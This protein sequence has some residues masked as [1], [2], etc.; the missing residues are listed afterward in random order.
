MT[1]AVAAPVRTVER[2]QQACR[3]QPNQCASTRARS[4]SA[5]ALQDRQLKL[6]ADD[7]GGLQQIAFRLREPVDAGADHCLDRRRQYIGAA[8]HAPPVIAL[9]PDKHDVLDQRTNESLRAKWSASAA[10]DAPLA[11]FGQF[12]PLSH[13][14]VYQTVGVGRIE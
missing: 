12:G 11:N 7:G 10:L 2:L 5:D 13:E 9:L 1:E 3:P 4:G 14:F 6:L 8:D